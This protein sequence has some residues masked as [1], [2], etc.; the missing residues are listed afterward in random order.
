MFVIYLTIIMR[1]F[2][3]DYPV[4]IIVVKLTDA[5][6]FQTIKIYEWFLYYE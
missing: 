4:N 6:V 2:H 1:S 5:N 3:F